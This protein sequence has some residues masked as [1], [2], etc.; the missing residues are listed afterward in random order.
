MKAAGPALPC[1]SC[2]RVLDHLSWHTADSGA[3]WHCGRGYVF[4]G[5]PALAA[6]TASTTAQAALATEDAVCFFHAENRA[7][8]VCANCGR[9]LCAVCA[10]DFVGKKTCP[11][12]IA[13]KKVKP[14]EAA[15]HRVLL[16]GIALS[17]ALGPLLLWPF[18]LITAPAA[19]GVV[20]YGWNKPGSL[21]RGKRVRF[22]IA[23]LL[24]LAQI[25]AW[26]FFFG[27]LIFR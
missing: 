9:F 22:V 21:V 26:A 16:D 7:E 27:R 17:L 20:I 1:P 2:R 6:G 23:G 24:A 10:V 15:P 8:V 13:T 14:A 12:C 4:Y 19:L 25:G 3:C 18:T 5:M 11:T